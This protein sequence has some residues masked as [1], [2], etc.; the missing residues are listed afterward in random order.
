MDVE[1][2]L[3]RAH[4]HGPARVTSLEK[5]CW[6]RSGRD[7]VLVLCGELLDRDIEWRR[8]RNGLAV[9]D[10]SVASG[11]LPDVAAGESDDP[12]QW[13]C[14]EMDQ[15]ACD[16]DVEWQLV[17][18][19]ALLEDVPVDVFVESRGIR[20]ASVGN[21]GLSCVAASGRPDE[22][23][24]DVVSSAL[25]AGQPVVHVLLRD[26]VE[27][28]APFLGPGEEVGGAVDAGAGP[29]GDVLCGRSCAGA[30][31]QAGQ[32]APEVSPGVWTQGLMPQLRV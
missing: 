31:P 13:L 20:F 4:G 23:V 8:Q 22:E 3:E 25:A 17:V 15:G 7:L 11:M 2:S 16:F 26:G 24:A 27:G 29:F 32:D 12:A 9:E 18:V 10:E 1:P 28:L 5:P 14:V 21:K 6:R 19:K 30:S